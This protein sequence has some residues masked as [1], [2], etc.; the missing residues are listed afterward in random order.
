MTDTGRRVLP[1]VASP[2]GATIQDGGVNFAVYSEGADRLELCLFDAPDGDAVET[3]PFVERTGFVWHCFVA[4]LGAGQLYGLR[5][6]GPYDPEAGLRF[7]RAKLLID[8]YARAL[9][10]ALDWDAPLFGYAAGGPTLDL[11]MDARDDARGVPKCAVLDNGFDWE[12][13][14]PPRIAWNETLIY[15]THVKGF[16]MLKPEVPEELRGTYAG[17]A[18]PGAIDH[19]KYL[20]VTAVE[21]LPVHA[22]VDGHHLASKGL[23]NYWGYD[24][25]SFFVPHGAYAASRDTAEQVREFK[26]MVKAL[27]RAGIEV[28]LDVVYNHT[29]EG[30]HLGPTLSFRGLDNA[31]YYRLMPEAPRYYEDFTGTGNTLNSSH[32]QVLALIMD[33]LRYWVTEMHIDGFRFDL[34]AALARDENG[35]TKFSNF[36]DAIHQDP[37]VSQVKLIA[38]PWDI[39]EDGYQVGNF[40]VLWTEWNGKFRDSV[41]R[42]W[43]GEENLAAEMGYR[44]C[45]SSDLYEGD[46]RRPYASINFVTAHDGFTLADLVSYEQKHNEANGEDNRDGAND[47]DSCNWGVEGPTD[48]EAITALRERVQRSLMATLVFSQGVPMLLGGDELGRTQGGNNNAYCQDNEIS[49]YDWA[50]SERQVALLEF[51][52]RLFA[53]RAEHPALHRKRFF[54]GRDIH[55][56]G[57]KD[58]TWYQPDG[59]EMEEAD[60]E[61]PWVQC[62]GVRWDGHVEDVDANGEP[63]VGKTVLLLFNADA[64]SHDFVLPGHDAGDTWRVAVDTIAFEA[65]DKRS[66]TGETYGVAD[67][68][69]VLLVAE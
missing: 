35:V 60:W 39:G 66:R 63:V 65:P 4:G 8:P 51:T 53:L 22:H 68:A 48:D 1:G 18:H 32:P 26:G 3:V 43:R 15:E 42:F 20:G 27:H 45:G 56:E 40:P 36:F 16:T 23:T 31:T 57:V 44:L 25:I 9:A 46:G 21:L 52:K 6:H 49:W 59:T 7:N 54:S 2:L 62:F 47:N 64:A 50:L 28:I 30:S 37:V 61:T 58:V 69:F 17:L 29:S 13:D 19:L 33:S 5:A 12:D 14:A 10:G 11:A 34:A 67:R 41:R 24:T 55:G 38:E